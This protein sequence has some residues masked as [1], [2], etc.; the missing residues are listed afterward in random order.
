MT[1]QEKLTTLRKQKGLSQDAL[2]DKLYVSRQA[3]Y[4][5][6]TGQSIPDI[7]KLRVLS[8]LYN[9][10][11]DNLLNNK[12][13]IR[14]LTDT[15]TPVT[16]GKVISKKE[17][18]GEEADVQN[19]MLLPD[20]QKQFAARKNA[21]KNAEIFWWLSFLLMMFGPFAGALVDMSMIFPIFIVGVIAFIVAINVKKRSKKK[22]P[23]VELSRTWFNQELAKAE[24]LLKS[25]HDT[26]IRLQD[27]LLAWFV[28]SHKDKVFGIYFDGDYQFLCPLSNFAVFEMTPSNGFAYFVTIKYF[29][30]DGK[31]CK[32][33]ADFHCLRQ[34]DIKETT[35]GKKLDAKQGYRFERTGYI[36][37]EIK[38]KLEIEKGR[39]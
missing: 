31:I 10:S 25:K 9:V 20:E 12:E 22:Y 27:D 15:K 7:E 6:E 36:L 33:N 29:D 37:G 21:L 2:A 5:W 39:L 14:Y 16:Y 28:Y 8:S 26:V 3:V 38:S 18:K 34:Y 30:A 19:L 11:I 4:K 13:E 23:N 17:L 32:Y 24:T 1:L 35:S